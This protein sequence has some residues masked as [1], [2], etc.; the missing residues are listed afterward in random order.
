MKTN[1][2]FTT[3]E[4]LLQAVQPPHSVLIPDSLHISPPNPPVQFNV[5]IRG[6]RIGGSPV[7]VAK[8]KEAFGTPTTVTAPLHMHFPGGLG[9]RGSRSDTS[10]ASMEYLA[11]S[12]ELFRPS[13]P[14]GRPGGKY[15]F[16]TKGDAVDAF[17]K[18]VNG[19]KFKY[20]RKRSGTAGG[21][22]CHSGRLGK[23]DPR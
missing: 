11:Y 4:V 18:G 17:D 20:H 14:N 13:A 16:K 7:F 3:Y 6:Y 10:A 21:Q 1:A 15:Q 8:L 12:F 2:T 19:N 23:M 9:I 22:G 5:H